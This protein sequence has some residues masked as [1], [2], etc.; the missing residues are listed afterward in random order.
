MRVSSF[1]ARV[2]ITIKL[3]EHGATSRFLADYFEVPAKKIYNALKYLQREK[4]V[5][6]T[7][8]EGTRTRYYARKEKAAE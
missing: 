7:R 1:A 3:C 6:A 5:R 8:F 2:L 4:L